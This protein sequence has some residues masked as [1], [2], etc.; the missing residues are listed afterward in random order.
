MGFRAVFHFVVDRFIVQKELQLCQTVL[1]VVVNGLSLLWLQTHL[2]I[3]F[4]YSATF[5]CFQRALVCF[6]AL[7]LSEARRVKASLGWHVR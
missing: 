1:L 5:E 3:L 4:L 7:A 2:D 6:Y